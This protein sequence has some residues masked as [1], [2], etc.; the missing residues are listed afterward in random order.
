MSKATGYSLWLV[1][2]RESDMYRLLNAAIQEIARHYGTPAFEPHV[3]LLGGIVGDSEEVRQK[4]R[5]LASNL[6]PYAVHLG[7]IGSHGTYFQILF[8]RVA[9]SE[10]V[11]AAG[12][13]A[14]DVFE[15]GESIYFPHCS[16]AYGDFSDEDLMSAKLSLESCN[17]LC[18]ATFTVNTIE[19]W[20]TEGSVGEWYQVESFPFGAA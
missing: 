2:D 9:Q 14:R 17:A 6:V 11:M 3:T 15:I 12:Q 16:F 5:W 10:E 8:S 13:R 7:T 18:A 4:T 19:L 1:P 20:R